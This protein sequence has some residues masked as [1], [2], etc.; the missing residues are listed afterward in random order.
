MTDQFEKMMPWFAI[1]ILR[2]KCT[3]RGVI[4]V[5]VILGLSAGWAKAE[6]MFWVKPIAGGTANYTISGSQ[7]GG[8]P[9]AIAGSTAAAD[10]YSVW[11][12]SPAV[13]QTIDFDL[14]A[15]IKGTDSNAANDGINI[16]ALSIFSSTGGLGVQATGPVTL[17]ACL[18]SSG[19]SDGVVGTNVGGTATQTGSDIGGPAI[20]ATAP[21][22]STA[23]IRLVTATG[24]VLWGNGTSGSVPGAGAASTN[25][26]G[27]SD[28]LIGTFSYQLTSTSGVASIWSQHYQHTTN[29]TPIIIAD[30]DDNR[31][32]GDG[33]W[34]I[35]NTTTGLGTPPAVA[36]DDLIPVTIVGSTTPGPATYFSGASVLR[37]VVGNSGTGSITIS[38][39]GGSTGQVSLPP[40]AGVNLTFAGSTS[41]AGLGGLATA[42]YTWSDSTTPGPRSATISLSQDTAG[43]TGAPQTMSVTGA[44]VNN[45]VVT[46]SSP[47]FLIHLGQSISQPITLSTTGS[48]NYYTRVS[49]NNAG[50]DGNGFSVSGRRE[51]GF[52]RPRRHR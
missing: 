44:V 46:S 26:N 23:W 27:W 20:G 13:G 42:A 11:L 6:I 2:G 9:A 15:S 41:V 25:V 39:S 3:L 24:Q 47:S 43:D 19:F 49:V 17:N 22:S 32:A 35:R 33:T 36:Y 30:S 1:Q 34:A 48:D 5:P 28:I 45:R 12:S 10:A 51:S 4:L 38:N 50:P 7:V 8:D 16:A 52:Q 40:V 18:Q 21:A 31:T 14:Y 37:E 29:S